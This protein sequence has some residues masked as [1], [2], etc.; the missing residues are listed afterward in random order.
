MSTDLNDA[1]D[2]QIMANAAADEVE[3][4]LF[5][6]C[7]WIGPRFAGTESYRRAADYMLSRFNDYQL[8]DAHLE[9]FEFNAWRRGPAELVMTEPFEDPIACYALPYGGSTGEAGITCGLV[10]VEDG[11]TEQIESKRDALVGRIAFV[12]KPGRHRMEIYADCLKRN[13]A[14]MVLT[15]R[16]EGM[17][18]CSGSV[19]DA[20]EGKIPAVS[21]GREAGLKL[22][23]LAKSH[24]VSLRLKA[25][26]HCE[27]DVTWNVVGE[28]R[29]TE[30]PDEMVIVGGHLDSH[31]I[32][33][34]AYDNAAGAVMVTE[35]AR[36]LASQRAHLK[37]TVRFICF[38]G[39]EVGLLGSKHHAQAHAD[40]LARARLMYNCDMP[41]I[42]KPWGLV[43]HRCPQ[44]VHFVT[45]LAEQLSM[46]LP[47]RHVTHAKS[48]HYPF[49]LLG[50]PAM[51][52]AGT[53]P[54]VGTMGFGHMAGDTPERIPVDCLAEASAFS[55]RVIVRA[56][57]DEQWPG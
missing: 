32:G 44:A 33:P 25:I 9:P 48:D 42:N 30:H 40:E 12:S 6:L 24:P 45:R 34:G 54:K 18:L 17:I 53:G 52:L 49:T 57:N 50:I 2:E 11:S 26:S 35:M 13:A 5:H 22:Q 15:N 37:R 36:L 14:G 31:E 28:L 21:I 10:D 29:G 20:V 46:D 43:L 1:I 16:A 38:G 3:R 7:D 8:D 39:E 19:T 27:T 55:A 47:C 23:R 56:A 41:A 51:A 4:N